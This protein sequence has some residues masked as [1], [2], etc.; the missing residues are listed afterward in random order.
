M[1][2]T[3]TALQLTSFPD[4][5]TLHPV[6]RHPTSSGWLPRH[7]VEP[8]FL[9][10]M[11]PAPLHSP[12][13]MRQISNLAHAIEGTVLALAAL[14][15]M[16]QGTGRMTDGRFRYLWPGLITL[17]G[18]SLLLYLLMPHHG[19]SRA[20]MQW[21][22]VFGD[23]QQ[24]QHLII[25]SLILIAGTLELLARAGRLASS[26]WSLAWPAAL[27]VVGVLF[28]VHEQH[29]TSEA[30]ARATTIHRYL[31]AVLVLAGI[32]SGLD[33]TRSRQVRWLAYAWGLMLLAAAVL[34]LAY[35]EPPGAYHGTMP[36]LDSAASRDRGAH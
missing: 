29:G 19:L 21:Q 8:A 25:A 20:R 30:V 17:A 2:Y 5:R 11:Q 10:A 34:L 23:P 18:A 22:F 32:L 16:A 13:E 33:V 12:E 1:L 7:S 31:G 27:I 3:P 26:G 35:R 6:K 9:I 15:A 4:R 36:G 14:I 28:V 24:R